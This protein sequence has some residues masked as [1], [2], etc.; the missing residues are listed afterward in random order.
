MSDE[1]TTLGQDL[2]DIVKS[3]GTKAI[4]GIKGFNYKDFA[5]KISDKTGKTVKEVKHMSDKEWCDEK[6]KETLDWL[7]KTGDDIEDTADDVGVWF[8]NK[9]NKRLN[10]VKEK[11]NEVRTRMNKD[12]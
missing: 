9:I 10:A 2:A 5:K 8:K 6:Y 4:K 11:A 1:K 7:K 3:G 12:E